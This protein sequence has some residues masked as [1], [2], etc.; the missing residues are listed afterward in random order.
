MNYIRIAIDGPAASGKSTIAKLV[1]KEFK[2]DY[3]D[4]GSMYRAITLKALKLGINIEKESEF[5]FVEHTTFEFKDGHLIMDGVDVSGKIRKHKVSNNVSLV[6]SYLSVRNSCVRIQQKIAENT[7]VVMDGRDIGTKVLT[8]ADFKFFLTASIEKRAERRYQDNI[9]R[10]LD[11]DLEILKE[12]IAQRDHFDSNRKHSPLKPADDAII[13]DTSELTI[14]QVV[15]L[16]TNK[17][18]GI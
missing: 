11:S 15:A 10:G 18:R 2:Y 6:S 14:E 3:I 12:K 9:K 7:N 5:D 4:T 8:D 17:I 1:A 13:I 16:I